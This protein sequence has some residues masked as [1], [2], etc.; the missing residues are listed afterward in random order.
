MSRWVAAIEL[1]C[2]SDVQLYKLSN[3]IILSLFARNYRLQYSIFAQ[4]SIHSHTSK[5]ILKL[6]PNF[7]CDLIFI[8]SLSLMAFPSELNLM[9]RLRKV[10][11]KNKGEAKWKRINNLVETNKALGWIIWTFNYY[12][13]IIQD[14]LS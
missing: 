6:L 11:F 5:T 10:F 13:F 12:Y 3:K 9:F 8:P 7:V 1:G 4:Y 14:S 2:F